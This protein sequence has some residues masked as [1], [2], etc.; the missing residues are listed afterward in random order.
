MALFIATFMGSMAAGSATWGRV[1]SATSTTT[2]LTIAVATGAVLGLLA[3]RW[4]LT[5]HAGADHSLAEI[6]HEPSAVGEPGAHEGP[7]MVNIEYLIDPDQARAFEAAMRD[8][9]RMRLRNGS[10]AWGLFQDVGDPGRYIEYFIDPT[11]VEHLR[12]R[13]RVT[14]EEADFNRVARA[15]HRGESPPRV[16]HYLARS[17]PKRRRSRHDGQ[18]SD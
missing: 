5:A 3:S 13:E 7:V 11:W 6:A 10:V 8:V 1:A 2:A 18:P 15:F 14:V 17:A 4:R 16:Q 9:R 12:R